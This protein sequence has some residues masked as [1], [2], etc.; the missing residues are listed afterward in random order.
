[1]EARI[2]RTEAG[3]MAII[4]ETRVRTRTLKAHGVGLEGAEVALVVQGAQVGGGI[5]DPLKV[6][7]LEVSGTLRD[8]PDLDLRVLHEVGLLTGCLRRSTTALRRHRRAATN[9]RIRGAGVRVQDLFLHHRPSAPGVS[10]LLQPRLTGAAAA[11][12]VGLRLPL[13]HVGPIRA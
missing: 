13:L 1:M 11:R 2:T 4:T 5:Q 3:A 10:F 7:T 9:L 8:H 6:P 12:V